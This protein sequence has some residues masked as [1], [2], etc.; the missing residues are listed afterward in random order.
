MSKMKRTTLAVLA[1][2][3][4]AGT[5]FALAN[6]SLTLG[7]TPGSFDFGPTFGGSQPATIQFHTFTIKP[8]E[9]IPW[10]HHKAISYVVLE[11]GTLTETHFDEGSQHCVSAEFQAGTGFV[12]EANEDHTVTNTGKSAAVITWATAFPAKDGLV[13]ISPEFTV[14]GIYFVDAPNCN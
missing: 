4:L 12:E 2:G 11:R 6:I 5:A 7:S 8:G 1:I 9:V 14:G 13:R 10:H 3:V